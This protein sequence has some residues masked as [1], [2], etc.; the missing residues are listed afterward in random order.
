MSEERLS[1]TLDARRTAIV[2]IDLQNGIVSMPGAPSSRPTVVANACADD[3]CS[4][5]GSPRPAAG[6]REPSAN[7]SASSLRRTM[8]RYAILQGITA[9]SSNEYTAHSRW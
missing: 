3:F 2:V 9:S 7:R 8:Q 6:R 1:L 4:E 5:D